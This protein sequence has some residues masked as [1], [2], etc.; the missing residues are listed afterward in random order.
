LQIPD[1]EGAMQARRKQLD[2]CIAR[3]RKDIQESKARWRRLHHQRQALKQRI[4]ASQPLPLLLATPVAHKLSALQAMYLAGTAVHTPDPLSVLKGDSESTEQLRGCRVASIDIAN[5]GSGQ[6]LQSSRNSR[7][8]HHCAAPTTRQASAFKFHASISFSAVIKHMTPQEIQSRQFHQ[9]ELRH[10]ISAFQTETAQR[11]GVPAS[12]ICWVL[13]WPYLG[14]AQQHLCSSFSS[15][16]GACKLSSAVAQIAMTMETLFLVLEYEHLASVTMPSYNRP[17]HP[18]LDEVP[19]SYP[20]SPS[21]PDAFDLAAISV[22]CGVSEFIQVEE[23][24]RTVMEPL[25]RKY[26]ELLTRDKWLLVCTK[27]ISIGQEMVEVL[28]SVPDTPPHAYCDQSAEARSDHHP[29][30]SSKCQV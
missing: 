8:M 14:R 1:G 6:V 25:L 2:E 17:A 10:A 13:E 30:A 22:R 26:K 29:G 4:Q 21:P 16:R 28:R 15:W 24:L 23:A 19:T 20:T 18:I 9:Q 5:T 11:L 3:A 27:T 12:E 7:Y